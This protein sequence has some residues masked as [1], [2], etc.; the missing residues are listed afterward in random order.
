M[1]SSTRIQ[2]AFAQKKLLVGYLTAGDGGIERSLEAALA[3][4]KGGV[5]LLE[6]GLPFSD[7]IADGPVIQRA[8]ARALAQGTTMEQV[9]HLVRSIRQYSDIPLILFTYLNPLLQYLNQNKSLAQLKKAG[10]DGVLWV[11]ASLEECAPLVQAAQAVNLAS[12]FVIS[13][14]TSPERIAQMNE[15]GSG[16]LYYACRNGTTGV[17]DALPNNFIEKI[18]QIKRIT[19][20][21][22]VAGFGIS[23]AQ[24]AAQVLEHTDGVVVGSLFVKAIEQGASSQALIQ[25]A[26]SIYPQ[27]RGLS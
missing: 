23:N 20:L 13:P 1:N 22:V 25:L 16:F 4:I 18:R 6:I 12:I 9:L 26:Q 19:H 8:A 21:P 10:L 15:L 3:L 11:D 14:T 7:P 5:G 2:H 24:M 27:A 17:R